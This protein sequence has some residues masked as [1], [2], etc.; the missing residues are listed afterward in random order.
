ME[1]L[2]FFMCPHCWQ[3]I[4]MTLDLSVT[5]QAYVED[6]EVCCRPIEVSYAAS[7][8]AVEYFTA[9]PSS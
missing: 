5:C 4:S 3:R 1:E 9:R 7:E 6:C 8:G 2:H